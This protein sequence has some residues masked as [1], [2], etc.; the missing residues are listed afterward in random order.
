MTRG[1]GAG[2]D[3]R[4]PVTARDARANVMSFGAGSERRRGK[5][6][7]DAKEEEYEI[8]VPRCHGEVFG[9]G[10]YSF[11]KFFACLSQL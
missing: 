11:F 4:A 3:A 2:G 7:D 1:R 10:F 6:E 5:K 9:R 8:Y